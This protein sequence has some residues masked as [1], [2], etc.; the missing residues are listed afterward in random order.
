MEEF[1]RQTQ[2]YGEAYDDHDNIGWIGSGF[3]CGPRGA[4]GVGVSSSPQHVA[5][6]VWVCVWENVGCASGDGVAAWS[7]VHAQRV[8]GAGGNK[9]DEGR[10]RSR[11]R[12]EKAGGGVVVPPLAT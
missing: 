9:A 4:G 2:S 6:Q 11:G 5:R 3:C 1:A 7:E 12:E 10:D 8:E